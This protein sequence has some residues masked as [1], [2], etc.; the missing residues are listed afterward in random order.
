VSQADAAEIA[1]WL[2]QIPPNPYQ[3][4]PGDTTAPNTTDSRAALRRAIAA[5]GDEAI[6]W[7]VTDNIVDTTGTAG[8]DPDAQLTADFYREL[9]ANPRVQMIAAYPIFRPP[10]TCSW[11]CGTSLFAYGMYVSAFERPDSAE[12]HRLGGTTP[13][14]GGPTAEGLLWNVELQKLAAQYSGGQS[15][16]AGKGN[17]PGVPVRLKPIDTEA[18]AIAFSHPALSC[19]KTPFGRELRCTARIEVK[20]VLRHQTVET[21]QL[22]LANRLLLPRQEG[23]GRR[24]AWASP[25]CAGRVETV[26]WQVRNGRHGGGADPI[27]IG[28]LEPLESAVVDVHFKLPPV[29]VDSYRRSTILEVALSKE[30]VL[31]GL[32]QAEIRNFRTVLAIHPDRFASVY[33]SDQLPGIFRYGEVGS[34]AATYRIDARLANNGQALALL[35]L[36]GM[37]GGGLLILLVAMRFQ[38]IQFTVA[39]DGSETARLSMPRLSRRDLD[40]AGVVRAQMVRGWGAGYTLVPRRGARLR[41]DGATWVLRLGDDLGE[42]HRIVIKRGWTPAGRKRSQQDNW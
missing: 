28:P 38:T 34:A 37:G 42:E 21:A 15:T 25:V 27:E 18:L 13:G 7:L 17:L 16:A 24:L 8:A 30:I 11:M 29:V 20:N 2:K 6:L 36:L 9:A 32:L 1:S 22:R 5:A 12:F 10:L 3:A 40:V 41:R 39:V 14:G 19:P 33:G 35:A 31:D 4:Y 23:S 26:S